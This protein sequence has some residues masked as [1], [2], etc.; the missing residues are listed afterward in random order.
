VSKDTWFD[1]GGF[2]R[3]VAFHGLL[4]AIA[5]LADEQARYEW[6]AAGMFAC[7]TFLW[8]VGTEIIERNRPS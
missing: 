3:I 7:S 2:L 5:F 4:A 8:I 1:I 6:V